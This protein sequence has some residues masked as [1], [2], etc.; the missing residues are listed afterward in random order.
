M[1]AECNH[2]KLMTHLTLRVLPRIGLSPVTT[3]L[4]MAAYRQPFFQ[5]LGAESSHA[6]KSRAGSCGD[7]D[8]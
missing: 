2:A 1:A 5:K 7:C 6:A 4:D 3:S 8:W